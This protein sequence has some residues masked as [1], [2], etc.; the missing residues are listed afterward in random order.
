MFFF[1]RIIIVSFES[2][3]LIKWQVFFWRR[4]DRLI[5]NIIMKTKFL[6]WDALSFVVMKNWTSHK[7]VSLLFS[8]KQMNLGAITKAHLLIHAKLGWNL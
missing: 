1:L 2:E 8:L 4:N 7:V 5:Y 6:I 3:N